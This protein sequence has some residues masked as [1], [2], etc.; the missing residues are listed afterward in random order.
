M[1][2]SGR[3]LCACPTTRV[4]WPG[5]TD[6]V[7]VRVYCAGFRAG[8]NYLLF[9]VMEAHFSQTAPG[10]VGFL[11][12]NFIIGHIS[13]S[14]SDLCSVCRGMLTPSIPCGLATANQIGV[15][16]GDLPPAR[17]TWV[18]LDS[19]ALLSP[20]SATWI[21]WCRDVF[22]LVVHSILSGCGWTRPSTS[23]ATRVDLSL[24]VREDLT[25]MLGGPSSWSDSHRAARARS[26]CS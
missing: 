6:R 21:L 16:L 7:R 5:C 20:C 3:V 26:R 10:R 2:L 12:K 8:H 23:F 13:L 15:T 22:N 9:I 24:P 18:D 25:I 4:P 17:R 14:I 11:C 19:R 1:V